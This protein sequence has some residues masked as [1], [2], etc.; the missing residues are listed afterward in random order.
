MLFEGTTQVGRQ[1][2]AR[3]PA[4]PERERPIYLGSDWWEEMATDIVETPDYAERWE[5]DLLP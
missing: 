4:R 3:Q 5:S 1:L 2:E